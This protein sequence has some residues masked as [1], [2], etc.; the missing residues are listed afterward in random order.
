MRAGGG[1]EVQI[2]GADRVSR[3]VRAGGE[4]YA[5]REPRRFKH[6]QRLA[7]IADERLRLRLGGG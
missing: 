2:D 3:G 1:G 4:R 6:G 7:G 5:A